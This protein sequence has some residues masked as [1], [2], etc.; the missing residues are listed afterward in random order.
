M[1][2]EIEYTS[3]PSMVE[4][5]PVMGLDVVGCS[6]CSGKSSSVPSPAPLPVM[7][8]IHPVHVGQR[9]FCCGLH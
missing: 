7:A 1:D 3:Y 2:D 9:A 5:Q 8:E 4:E 6:G